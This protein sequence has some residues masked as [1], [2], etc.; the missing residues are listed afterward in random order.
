M[1][2]GGPFEELRDERFD[3]LIRQG[4]EWEWAL[5]EIT[6]GRCHPD[7]FPVDHM[8]AWQARAWYLKGQLNGV[9]AGLRKGETPQQTL[10]LMAVGR[11]AEDGMSEEEVVQGLVDGT[12]PM[13]NPET[14]RLHYL[15]EPPQT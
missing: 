9:V 15:G 14:A 1:G 11:L 4:G 7:G 10:V 12:I 13:P 2:D 5:G 3:E 6:H 8:R